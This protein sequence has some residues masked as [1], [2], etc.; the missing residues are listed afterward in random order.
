MSNCRPLQYFRVLKE[1]VSQLRDL[2]SDISIQNIRSMICGVTYWLTF[3]FI[4]SYSLA[5]SLYNFF[6]LCG[7]FNLVSYSK[8]TDQEKFFETHINGDHCARSP[9]GNY[10]ELRSAALRFHLAGNSV[11][12][13][14][15]KKLSRLCHLVKYM[16]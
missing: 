9:R 6:C 4:H 3:N 13:H 15:Q 1:F 7:N 8:N 2:R 14:R 11:R 10:G 5:L 16:Q 12:W